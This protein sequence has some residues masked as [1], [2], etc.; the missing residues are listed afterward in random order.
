MGHTT[1]W[2][3]RR[4]F[5]GKATLLSVVLFL[6]III[7]NNIFGLMHPIHAGVFGFIP[8]CFLCLTA[9]SRHI[10]K[11]YK[12]KWAEHGIKIA[13]ILTISAVLLIIINKLTGGFADAKKILFLL[14]T[15]MGAL[16]LTAIS[17]AVA[18]TKTR[19]SGNRAIATLIH[20]T[21]SLMLMILFFSTITV[22]GSDS[23][24]AAG[25][26]SLFSLFFISIALAIEVAI[27]YICN[28]FAPRR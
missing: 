18:A 13:V 27:F 22:L 6:T 2:K 19:T 23:T 8:A 3:K 26:A 14:S 24:R 7:L 12:T 16:T 1:I 4:K 15:A 20:I 21:V 28:F 11:N 17:T 10:E 5:F 9:F 25:V